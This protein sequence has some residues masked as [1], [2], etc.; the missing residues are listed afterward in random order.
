MNLLENINISN[1]FFQVI[2][3]I[4]SCV[5]YGIRNGDNDR[6]QSLQIIR[7]GSLKLFNLAQEELDR[8]KNETLRKP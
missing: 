7:E 2:R 6:V 5:F 8:I 1:K 3:E 4:K